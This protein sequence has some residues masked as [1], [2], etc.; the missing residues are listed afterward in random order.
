MFEERLA[1]ADAAA[2]RERA[3]RDKEAANDKLSI[4]KLRDQLKEIRYSHSHTSYSQEFILLLG[5]CIYLL[6]WNVGKEER[7]EEKTG[8]HKELWAKK[9]SD[10]FVRLFAKI[11][12]KSRFLH[13]QIF[14]LQNH[15]FQAFNVSK[16][17]IYREDEKTYVFIHMSVKVYRGGGG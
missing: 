10:I 17:Y 11:C 13:N 8:K 5:I 6:V 12:Q 1:E 7:G 16:T 9:F 15:L 14:V 2:D 3:E 4:C